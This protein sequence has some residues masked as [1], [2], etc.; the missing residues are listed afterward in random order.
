MVE[1]AYKFDVPRETISKHLFHSLLISHLDIFNSTDTIVDAGTGGG[2]P[3]IPLAITY[4]EKHYILNDIVSKKCLALKQISRKL[5][6]QN[7]EI[8]DSSIEN[9]DQREAFLLIS[10][11]AFKINDLYHM[12]THLPWEAIV[13]Y[14]G[15]DFKQELEGIEPSLSIDCYDLSNEG[16]FYQG[17]ALITI[18]RN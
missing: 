2:L 16:D 4:P 1:R 5:N 18:R 12:T 7:I 3:G 8:V 9:I 14:K 15:T 6:L 10:K 17:K 13:L 11:H